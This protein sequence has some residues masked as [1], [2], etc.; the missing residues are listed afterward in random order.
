MFRSIILT[1]CA[2]LTIGLSAQWAQLPA[3]PNE[4]YDD[5]FFLNADTGWACGG[6]GRVVRTYD[7]GA[8]WEI[9]LNQTG[10]L[11]SIE[12]SDALHGICGSLDSLVYRTTDGGDTW[13]EISDQLAQPIQGICG[14]SAPT[15]DVFYGS[16]VVFTPA[17][18]VKSTDAGATWSHIDM[19][20]HSEMLIDVHFF[21]ADTGL[22]TGGSWSNNSGMQILRTTDGGATWTEVLNT[23]T[24]Q[25]WGWKL[26]SPDGIHVYASIE[27]WTPVNTPTRIARS[28]DRGLTWTLDTISPAPIRL[29][30][31]GFLTTEKGWA[32]DNTLLKTADG[33]DTWA[34]EISPI[35]SFNR[36]HRVNDHLAFAGAW[37]IYRY[38]ETQTGVT[39]FPRTP[40]R[41]SIT[42]S[43]NPATGVVQVE[44]HLFQPS[45]AHVE[46]RSA[47]GLLLE[48]LHDG[49]STGGTM[50][51]TTDLS[52]YA[53]GTYHF[54][55][56]TS[57]GPSHAAVVKQ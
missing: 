5:I 33:G 24:G 39:S 18:V 16:G 10:Y 55:L 14:I 36:F 52:R 57:W 44:A 56:Y 42:V 49:W 54:V 51:F 7:G 37:G 45:Y 48:R 11:R 38:N 32:G 22:V 6:G 26:Q 19:S 21:D 41:E 13:T 2:P 28:N 30:G 50:R 3:P 9:V 29:Q 47:T 17:F 35:Q 8:S 27:V 25:E 46:L 31:I 43:P 53:P 40:D 12:F 20:A 15:P 4:R 1:L 23:G 34:M